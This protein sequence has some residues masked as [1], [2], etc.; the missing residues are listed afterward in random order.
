MS[1]RAFD[2]H[3]TKEPRSRERLR[4]GVIRLMKAR[5]RSSKDVLAGLP[6]AGIAWSMCAVSLVLTGLGLILLALSRAHYPG[7]PVFEQWVEDAVVAVSFSTVGA[8]VA[9]RFPLRNP[10]GWLFCS[11]GLLAG[12]LL[13]SGEYVSYSMLARP[14][15]LPGGETFA[16]ISS[17]LWVPHVGLYAFLALLFPDGRPPTPRWRPLVW[18]LGAAVAAGTVAAALSP[19][20]V[21]GLWAVYNPRG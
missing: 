11:I 13:F 19:G 9:P 5:A 1:T 16:W 2:T 20:P 4:T 12:M 8:I 17:W 15:A 21:G 18:V 7:V 6:P 3:A 14:G 10:I